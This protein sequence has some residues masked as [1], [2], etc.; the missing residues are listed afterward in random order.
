[1]KNAEDW[2]ADSVIAAGTYIAE[3]SVGPAFDEPGAPQNSIR[4]NYIL[5]RLFF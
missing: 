4:L 3:E 1:M 2:A 5:D